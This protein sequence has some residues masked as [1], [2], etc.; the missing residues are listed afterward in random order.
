MKTNIYNYIQNKVQQGTKMIAA[1]IDPDKN[2]ER[3]L[4]RILPYCEE[5]KI[6][7][8][9]IGGSLL[10]RDRLEFTLDFIKNHSNLPCILFPGSVMQISSKA[11]AILFLSLISGR[12]PELLIGNHVIAA[13]YIYEAGLET[14]STGY[15]LIHCGNYTTAHYMSGCMPIPSN[16]YEIAAM[17]ALAGQMLGMKLIYMDGGSGAAHPIEPG[18]IATVRKIIQ[19]PIV[20][21]GGI[22]TE[23]QAKQA[24]EAGAD[25]IVVGNALESS[26]ELLIDLGKLKR[27]YS[28]NPVN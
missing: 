19:I 28:S 26:P 20:V 3:S 5:A 27:S 21:G 8:L 10:V 6:D 22:R 11:D 1:L 16:K 15:M 12:N 7:F 4:S 23:T 14:I 17:T 18:M 9:F 25:V 13:P 24:F 2:D